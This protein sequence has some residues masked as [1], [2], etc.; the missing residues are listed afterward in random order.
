MGLILD[1]L[2][3]MLIGM[4]TVYVFLL[5]MIFCMNV[6]GKIL[7]PFAAKIEAKEKEAKNLQQA[8]MTPCAQPLR[9]PLLMQVPN[10]QIR[11]TFAK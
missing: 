7:A 3:L 11:K 1:G 6:L 2:K 5:I 4:L 9:Q 10:N 8:A